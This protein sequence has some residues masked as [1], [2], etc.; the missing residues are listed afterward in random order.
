MLQVF[1]NVDYNNI[2][3]INRYRLPAS[4]DC[5]SLNRPSLNGRVDLD[6]RKLKVV[7]Y[8]DDIA[9]SMSNLV[10]VNKKVITNVYC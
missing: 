4:S 6:W 3:A 5:H 9:T 8:V 1:S 2:G 10:P 7:S